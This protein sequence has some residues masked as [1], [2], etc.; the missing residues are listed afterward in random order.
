MNK[1]NFL[2]KKYVL[3]LIALPFLIFIAY[4]INQFKPTKEASNLVEV[5]EFNSQLQDPTSSPTSSNNT[6]GGKLDA[7]RQRLKRE[8][9]FTGIQNVETEVVQDEMVQNSASLYT[10]EEMRAIDSINQ[11]NAIRAEELRQSVDRYRSQDFTKDDPAIPQTTPVANDPFAQQIQKPDGEQ[12]SPE[13]IQRKRIE[14]QMK[15]LDSITEAR[16]IKVGQNARKE[17][18]ETATQ[19]IEQPEQHTYQ[20]QT[21]EVKRSKEV[22]NAYFNTVGNYDYNLGISAI[23]DE[24]L[25]V[26]QGSRVRIRLLEDVAIGNYGLKAG[27]Y[28][29]GIVSGFTAQRVM[30]TINS[31]MV[32]GKPT[33]VNLSVFDIDGMEGFYIPQSA[34]R[35]AAKEAGSKA[36]QQNINVNS[37]VGSG[38]AQFTYKMLQ[39]LYQSSTQALGKNIRGNKAKLK[40][41][42]QVYLVNKDEQQ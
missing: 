37:G 17:I 33:K 27:E 36:S 32:N 30:I 42:T 22:S 31:I 35:D 26:V 11:V 14:E 38:L 3:P 20:E 9:D 41:A 25:K 23:L 28:L 4:M 16:S 18:E 29:Y 19:M 2:Q 21:V 5:E 15:R 7:L 24:G 12:L 8:G 10:T 6:T 1:I 40:Y 13:E 39:D 34:F